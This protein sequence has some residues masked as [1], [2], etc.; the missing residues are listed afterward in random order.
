M[1]TANLAAQKGTS[2]RAASAEPTQTRDTDTAKK[3]DVRT[4]RRLYRMY[5]WVAL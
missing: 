2:M 1:T 4:M 3:G 5:Y